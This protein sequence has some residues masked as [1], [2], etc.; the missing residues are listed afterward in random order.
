MTCTNSLAVDPR[1]PLKQFMI[2]IDDRSFDDDEEEEEELFNFSPHNR[3]NSL[4]TKRSG[5]FPSPSNASMLMTSKLSLAIFVSRYSRASSMTQRNGIFLLLK[6]V[7]SIASTTTG[8]CSTVSISNAFLKWVSMKNGKA[9]EP[10]PII[11]IASFSLFDN[12]DDD[13]PIIACATVIAAI[14]RKYSRANAV[15]SIVFVLSSTHAN[16]C[17][18]SFNSSDRQFGPYAA[19]DTTPLFDR[20]LAFENKTVSSASCC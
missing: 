2:N 11:N 8:S 13:C 15:P 14:V 16:P 17:S 6:H 10:K 4:E 9:P 1:T 19:T 3:K 7:R 20:S 12:D 18:T 5:T